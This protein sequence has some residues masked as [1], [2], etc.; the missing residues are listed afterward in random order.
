MI[1]PGRFASRTILSLAAAAIALAGMSAQAPAPGA[2]RSTPEERAVV[3]ELTKIRMFP[4]EYARYLRYLGTRFEGTLWRLKDHVPI[5]TEEGRE[6]VEEAAEFLETVKPIP[7][8]VTFSEGLHAAAWEHMM[9]QGPSGQT[10]H[11]GVSGSTFG[12]RIRRYGQPGSLIGEI[13]NY[14]KEVPRMTVIQLVIDDG[15]PDRGHRKNIFNPGFRTAG[16]AIGPHRT[17]GTMTVVDM[18][19]EFTPNRP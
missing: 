17:Y 4:R 14:G 11:V 18:A 6:A 15:V 16:A 19:D 13:I 8:E 2:P 9:D 7:G 10:G 12:Q 1:Q 3:W 5:R